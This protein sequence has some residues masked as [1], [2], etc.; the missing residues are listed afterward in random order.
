MPFLRFS[1]PSPTSPSD[2]KTVLRIVTLIGSVLSALAG[3]TNYAFSAY[4]PQLGS[5][6]H[7][8]HTQLNMIAAAG[9]VGVYSTGPFWGSIADARGP[10]LLY[11]L[12]TVLLFIGYSGVKMFYDGVFNLPN[13]TV[14]SAT[15]FPFLTILV[16]AYASGAGGN[17]GLIGSINAVARSFSDA[18][19]S[20][21]IGLVASGFGL[22]AFFFS[23]LA[24]S[25]FSDDTSA[26]LA[27]LA[28]GTTLPN[29]L[30]FFI[31]RIIPPEP[32]GEMN[33]K[34]SA[35]YS[36]L[37][38]AEDMDMEES[39][40]QLPST[41]SLAQSPTAR[42]SSRS[43]MRSSLERY[44]ARSP[45]S[46]LDL[47]AEF[48][49]VAV[50][51]PEFHHHNL[52]DIEED[53]TRRASSPTLNNNLVSAAGFAPDPDTISDLVQRGDFWLMFF[54]VSLMAGTGL[55]WINNVGSIAQALVA[56]GQPDT[57]DRSR[58]VK[59]QAAQVS[60]VSV[61]NSLGRIAIGLITDV[62][63][64]R[65]GIR[66]AFWFIP[67]AFIF[68]ASQ[69]L[70]S[71]TTSPNYLWLSSALLGTAYGAMFTLA[72][73]IILEWFGISRFSRNWG[74]VALSPVL[75]GNLFSIAFGRN[76]D[77]HASQEPMT[78]LSAP[79]TGLVAR[80]GLPDATEHLCYD[81][82]ACYVDSLHMT[83]V[84]SV[85]ALALA[86]VVV[87]RDRKIYAIREKFITSTR[88]QGSS[89]AGDASAAH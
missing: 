31:V 64:H 84:A 5:R 25:A 22:S 6:L 56:Q 58:A 49:D 11:F 13:E 44:R 2:N 43:R 86:G 37:D 79:I 32:L 16:F 67:T 72:P 45:A 83:I 73:M 69:T 26:F 29:V 76:L 77:K 24:H 15:S 20:S 39:T 78:L 65:Y 10:R 53:P 3:G 27:V 89:P 34:L 28:L 71:Y 33:T 57:W 59:L 47:P 14:H 75:G 42:R 50:Q 35:A 82:V 88:S 48:G 12:A 46:S 41:A 36:P 8:D 85:A 62:A 17:A 61:M 7:I 30:A 81:G 23:T 4:A 60:I 52:E 18:K 1:L 21:A 68:I 63:K 80:G 40:D 9:N 38:T 74:T 19:R 70:A 54:V 51:D 66:R 55:M 87:W